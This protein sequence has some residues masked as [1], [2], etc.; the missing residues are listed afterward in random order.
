MNI[1]ISFDPSAQDDFRKELDGLRELAAREDLTPAEAE[2]L[3]QQAA[4]DLIERVRI[5]TSSS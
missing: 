5:E 1:S 4:D 3:A 2:Q